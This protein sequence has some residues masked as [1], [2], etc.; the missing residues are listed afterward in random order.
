MSFL[1]HIKRQVIS[2]RN[3][4][5]SFDFFLTSKVKHFSVSSALEKLLS[6]FYQ[7]S[8]RNKTIIFFDVLFHNFHPPDFKY[9]YLS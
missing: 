1:W 2:L 9:M 8:P 7:L 3:I 5:S 6:N 4:P